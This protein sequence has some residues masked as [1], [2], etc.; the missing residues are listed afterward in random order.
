MKVLVV[1]AF[2]LSSSDPS[3]TSASK[4]PIA[5]R[6]RKRLQSKSKGD[7]FTVFCRLV[8]KAI[9]QIYVVLGYK[10]P[11]A[12]VCHM[13]N[14]SALDKLVVDWESGV[15]D[16]N[17]RNASML[18]DSFDCIFI[19]SSSVCKVLPWDPKLRNLARLMHMVNETRKPSWTSG[20]CALLE[21][22][23]AAL[24]GRLFSPVNGYRG[25]TLESLENFPVYSPP[26]RPVQQ[27]R[28]T[29]P[30]FYKGFLDNETGDVYVYEPAALEWRPVC[31]VGVRIVSASGQ[32]TSPRFAPR[33]RS[34]AVEQRAESAVPSIIEADGEAVL[35]IDHR[36]L[37]HPMLKGMDPQFKLQ[38]LPEWFILRSGHLPRARGG[39][40][41]LADSKKGPVFLEFQGT[42]VILAADTSE[43]RHHGTIEKLMQNFT[44]HIAGLMY[45]TT[46]SR[47]S[48]VGSSLTSFLF[49]DSLLASRPM[50]F[51]RVSGCLPSAPAIAQKAVRTSLPRGPQI[52]PEQTRSQN[53]GQGGGGGGSSTFAT[54]RDTVR[55]TATGVTLYDSVTPELQ[56]DE[57]SSGAETLRKEVGVLLMPE[58]RHP[59][60]IVH[61]PAKSPLASRPLRRVHLLVVTGQDSPDA[62]ALL[63]AAADDVDAKLGPEPEHREDTPC[64]TMPP[65]P[66]V[67]KI[68]NWHRLAEASTCAVSTSSSP[69][70][71]TGMSLTERLNRD[72]AH[73]YLPAS[74]PQTYRDST[75]TGVPLSPRSPTNATQLFSPVRS[76]PF[77]NFQKF[78]R[79]ATKLAAE[80]SAPLASNAEYLGA[81]TDGP[82]FSEHEREI[83][84]QFADRLR[85]QH[86]HPQGWKGGSPKH[87]IPLRDLGHVRAM[88][89]YPERPSN[90]GFEHMPA[91]DYA[92]LRVDDKQKQRGY[93][94]RN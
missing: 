42:K 7:E 68:E 14:A 92:I 71:T 62:R 15:L 4:N 51:S 1:N 87:V 45:S 12:P 76:K 54:G 74:H 73:N 58:T 19:G 32:P 44:K 8:A 2:V 48:R 13:V 52:L 47:Q 6:L 70:P 59:G 23:V 75:Q 41:C 17:A 34:Y 55:Y 93:W 65:H 25:S 72:R 50:E 84:S 85:F 82:Y 79:L 64:K 39:L 11:V 20:F 89:P 16:E 38:L 9:E 83:K 56:L 24:Q 26:P 67:P 49:G 80:A 36:Y 29:P 43:G 61:S 18:F 30:S 22:Q 46:S 78:Q 66:A 28:G 63:G 10:A 91:S 81:R 21:I 40:H 69:L 31:N 88:G 35:H 86:L 3:L 27:N 57:T 33:D 5:Q 60:T 94:I 37:Q 77:S 90:Q 53:D